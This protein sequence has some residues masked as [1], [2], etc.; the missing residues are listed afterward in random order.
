[1]ARG[2]AHAAG[3]HPVEPHRR[4]RHRRGAGERR[5][6]LCHQAFRHEG[7]GGALARGAAPQAPA[8]GREADLP[9]R[10][11]LGRSGQAHRPAGRAGGEALAQGIRH[12]AHPRAACRQ[13][14]DPPVPDEAYE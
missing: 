7:A 5:R 11:A 6:R 3:R 14:A 13:G 9:D 2:S 4:G 12:P 8:T 10:R 1:M